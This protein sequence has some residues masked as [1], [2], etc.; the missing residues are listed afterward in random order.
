MARRR[1]RKLPSEPI[2]VQITDLAH[3][4]RGVGRVEGKAVFVHGALPGETVRARVIDRARKHDEALTE[5]VLIASGDRVEPGCPWFDQCGGCALQHL[6]SEAQRA[7]KHKRLV[8]NLERIGEVSPERW[9]DPIADEP[10]HYRRRARLSARFVKGKGRVLVGFREPQGRFVADVGHCRV[11]H[12]AFSDRLESLSELLGSLSVAASVPQVEIA[13]G[14]GQAAMV[15]RHLEP[16][17]PDD[18]MRLKSWSEAEGVAVYLQSKGPDTVHRLCP[19][20]HQLSYRLEAHDLALNFH[21]QQFVQVNA[22]VNAR[23]IDRAIELMELQGHER[24]LDLFCGLGNFSLPLARRA[25]H[26]T[27]IEGLEDLV[28]SARANA[29][30]NGID[31][32]EF[33]VADLTE[34]VRDRAWYRAGFDAVL[35]DPPRSGA[36]EILPLMADCGAKRLVYVSCNP[37]TLARDAGELVRR[38]GFVLRAAGIADMFPHT[39]HVESIALFERA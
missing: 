33:E 21:P 22:T 26:V 17:T 30:L 3:D 20:E 9:L 11:L 37:A 29:A 16:L 10:W 6:S 1:R 13:A 5:E 35:I 32:V 15:L 19:D 39:A 12:P 4:G 7:W 24:V 8:D 18:L 14:D 28:E 25:E 27:G 2:E 36:L 38:H 34:D 31:N 23:L